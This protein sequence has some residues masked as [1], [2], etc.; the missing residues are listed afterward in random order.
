MD[1]YGLICI[2]GKSAD[3]HAGADHAFLEK[4]PAY[5]P[6]TWRR[7]A[8]PY[9]T[10]EGPPSNLYIQLEDRLQIDQ[11]ATSGV[12]GM[13][14]TARILRA[15]G[16]IIA[17][18]LALSG[19]VPF[20][21]IKNTFDLVEGYLLSL[22]ITPSTQSF[23]RGIY[24]VTAQIIRGTPPN[25]FITQTLFADYVVGGYTLGF[26]GG[27]LAQSVDGFGS[28]NS[29]TIAAPAAGVELSFSVG[30]GQRLR[31]RSIRF[32]LTTSATVANREVTLVIDD[33]AAIF[34]QIPSNFTQAASLS[35][36]YCFALGTQSVKGSVTTLAL[37]PLPDCLLSGG[38]RIRTLTTA[39]Q[40]TDQYSAAQLYHENWVE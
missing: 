34:A 20:T 24:F 37:S 7:A 14:V 5:D 31:P 35:E 21:H 15:D 22:V 23:Q 2:C 26:P 25:Q 40:A 28:T 6:A 1:T 33:G 32:S 27:R 3:Q 19:G 38:Y 11:V 16:T 8:A 18:Q 30:S 9:P 10:Q 4:R 29:L 17:L 12:I 39:I 36:T 13:T